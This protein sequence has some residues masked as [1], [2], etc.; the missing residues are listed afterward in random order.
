VNAALIKIV[1]MMDALLLR[2]A[3]NLK[4]TSKG[5]KAASQR[6]RVDTITLE[7]IAKDYRRESI[8]VEKALFRKKTSSKKT[9][10]N[11]RSLRAKSGKKKRS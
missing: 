6:V 3:R 4:K 7:K 11:K 10:T 2:I 9:K 8:E 1:E 5:N